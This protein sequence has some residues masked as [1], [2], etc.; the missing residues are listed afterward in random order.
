MHVSGP[1]GDAESDHDELF[2]VLADKLIELRGQMTKRDRPPGVAEYLDAVR[3]CMQLKV[4]PSS[5]SSA[6]KA[7]EEF[8]LRKPTDTT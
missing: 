7:I 4:N 3:A 6:W 8:T 5:S 2:D 1:D